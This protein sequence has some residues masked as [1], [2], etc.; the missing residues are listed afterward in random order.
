MCLVAALDSLSGNM[1]YTVAVA[2]LFLM[3]NDEYASCRRAMQREASGRTLQCDNWHAARIFSER[4]MRICL[5]KML[6]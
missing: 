1:R 2:T 3:L 6:V 4:R 5:I